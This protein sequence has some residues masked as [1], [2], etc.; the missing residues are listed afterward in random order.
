MD[1]IRLLR[2]TD[3]RVAVQ[4]NDLTPYRPVSSMPATRRDLSVAVPEDLDPEL[5]GD[6]VRAALG[7]HAEA[8]EEI[9][10][11]SDTGYAALPEGARERLGIR[12]G[13]KNV[14][15]RVLLRD[16]NSTLT[17]TRPTCCAIGSTPRC[18]P[19]T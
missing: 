4:M 1:D 3:P 13:Q 11:L 6:Q 17:A 5:L 8:V 12:R 2:S 10:V 19:G 15:L 18:T 16:L 14:L 7:N 9:Q